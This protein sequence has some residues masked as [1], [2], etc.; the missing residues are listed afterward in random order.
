MQLIHILI[1]L[2]AES[3]EFNDNILRALNKFSYHPSPS[4]FVCIFFFF[5]WEVL[6]QTRFLCYGMVLMASRQKFS[7]K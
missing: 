1:D 2:I 6:L 5:F 4:I 3:F 7:N